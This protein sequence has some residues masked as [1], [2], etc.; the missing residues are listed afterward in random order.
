MKNS[1]IYIVLLCFA[2]L[3]A[4]E[5]KKEKTGKDSSSGETKSAKKEPVA[6]VFSGDSAYSF[7]KRQVDFGPRVPNT[8]AHWKCG[9]YLARKLKS[10][11]WETRTQQ[12]EAKAFDGTTLHLTNIIG[13]YQPELAKRVLLA[14]H[15]DTRPFADQDA[16]PNRI[17]E[18]I[19]GANDGASGV[20]ALLE[21]ARVI[22]ESARK[23]AIGVDII[24]FDGEDYGQPDFAMDMGR[25]RDS[26]C[27]GSQYWAKNRHLPGY[28]AY[29]GI[30]LDMVGAANARFAKEGTSMHY[31]PSVV[32]KVWKTGHELGY[33]RYFVNVKT[34][35]I[36]DDHT[37]INE[38]AG[39]PMIDIIEYNMSGDGYFGD[40][41]HTHDDNMD[42]I[43]PETLKA[44]G[45]TVL[46]VLYNE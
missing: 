20:G 16:D 12:F 32:D 7:V 44:V 45:Q 40:Y 35:P 26:W 25:A 8:S 11:G 13:S 29:Y 21:M 34:Q 9:E 37:Y 28:M 6:P 27:L 33:G 41:W 15:W 36:I 5:D 24:F 30:L 19:D 4:C 39:L 22:S 2:C 10:Y 17:K 31:A 3:T 14:A 23:P 38:L 18:P 1:L 46:E 43:D 42:V